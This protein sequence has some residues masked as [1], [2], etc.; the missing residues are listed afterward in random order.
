[1]SNVNRIR[2]IDL[3]ASTLR[4]VKQY[5]GT[6]AYST[7]WR[8]QK[9]VKRLPPTHCQIIIELEPLKLSTG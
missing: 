2:P 9:K 5:R 6:D 8:E 4:K 1:M 7:E 3:C